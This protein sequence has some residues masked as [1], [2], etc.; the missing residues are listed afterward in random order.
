MIKLNP[1]EEIDN[2][3]RELH[4][5][6]EQVAS[7]AKTVSKLDPTAENFEKACMYF[8]DVAMGMMDAK[9]RLEEA[10]K[11]HG[12]F[13]VSRVDPSKMEALYEGL[14]DDSTAVEI[15]LSLIHI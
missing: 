10:L 9:E 5:G 2:L 12:R 15:P 6:I 8:D 4:R 13:D 11:H 7:G 14:Y 3:L 1:D